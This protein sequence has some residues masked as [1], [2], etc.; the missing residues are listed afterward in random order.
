[1]IE[2]DKKESCVCCEGNHRYGTYLKDLE[3]KEIDYNNRLRKVFHDLPSGT[4]IKITVEV[5]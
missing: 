5:L 1:M 2:D 4:K 3:D